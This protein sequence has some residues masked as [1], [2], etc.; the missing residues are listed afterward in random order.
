MPPSAA[1]HVC[2]EFRA[3]RLVWHEPRKPRIAA[4]SRML[5]A[6]SDTLRN[7]HSRRDDKAQ[8]AIA[9]TTRQRRTSLGIGAPSQRPLR[10]SRQ[11]AHD[12][13]VGVL[14]HVR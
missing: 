5:R 14:D 8:P 4:A 3:R 13:V 11:L 7:D 12:Q 1:R 2:R 6:T 10:R 9:R